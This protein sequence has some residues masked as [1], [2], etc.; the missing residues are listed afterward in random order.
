MGRGLALDQ[1]HAARSSPGVAGEQASLPASSARAYMVRQR[2]ELL[3]VAMRVSHVAC[4][5]PM[6]LHAQGMPALRRC[7]HGVSQL[8]ASLKAPAVCCFTRKCSMSTIQPG[9]GNTRP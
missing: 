8:G 7:W 2:A 4:C 6:P 3:F 9:N 1:W 5:L